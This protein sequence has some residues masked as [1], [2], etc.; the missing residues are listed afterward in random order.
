MEAGT[1]NEDSLS[2]LKN[3]KDNLRGHAS[4]QYALAMLY[5][6]LKMPDE[7]V[8]TLQAAIGT[9]DY[10]K[11]SPLAWGVY[12]KICMQYGFSE[13][14]EFALAQARKAPANDFETLAWAGPL[15]GI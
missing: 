6:V 10:A 14:A 15:L 8:Q 7:A 3:L 4:Y 13:E 1:A 2:K 9:D 11:I 5:A 12:A